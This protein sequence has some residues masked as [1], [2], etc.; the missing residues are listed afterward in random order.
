M[1]PDTTL[2]LITRDV[3]QAICRELRP[4]VEDELEA[5]DEVGRPLTLHRKFATVPVALA[6]V[7]WGHE[8]DLLGDIDALTL[9]TLAHQIGLDPSLVEPQLFP[10]HLPGSPR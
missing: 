7:D 4:L 1:R 3:I 5:D 6:Q 2:R 8:G 9:V 10:P